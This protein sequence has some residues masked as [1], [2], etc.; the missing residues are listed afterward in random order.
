VDSS[1]RQP[2]VGA[3]TRDLKRTLDIETATASTAPPKRPRRACTIK[4]CTMLLGEHSLVSI[5][6]LEYCFGTKINTRQ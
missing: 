4:T 3:S 5:N 6:L 2:S 1:I